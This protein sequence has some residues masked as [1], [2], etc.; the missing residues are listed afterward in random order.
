MT[1]T[2]SDRSNAML[3]KEV[4]KMTAKKSD[5]GCGC[6]PL[7]GKSIKATTDKDKPRKPK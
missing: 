4:M 7:K 1:F 3:R 5:C 6:I 2:V